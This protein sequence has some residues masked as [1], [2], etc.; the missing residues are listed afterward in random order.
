MIANIASLNLGISVQKWLNNDLSLSADLDSPVAA[1]QANRSLQNG[2]E[3]P[4]TEQ[5]W[6][7]VFSP[8]GRLM[9]HLYW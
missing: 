8:T 6:S 9:L 1:Y 7:A 4:E 5:L 2:A 3:S